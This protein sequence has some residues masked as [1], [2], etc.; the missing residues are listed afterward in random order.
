M[1]VRRRRRLPLRTRMTIR[2]MRTTVMTMRARR[3]ATRSRLPRA[4]NA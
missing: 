1:K 4:T 3:A 2:P